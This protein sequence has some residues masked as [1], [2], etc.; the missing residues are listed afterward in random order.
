MGSHVIPFLNMG[1]VML[2]FHF[3]EVRPVS[4][5]TRNRYA[6]WIINSWPPYVII[7]L[8]MLSMPGDLRFFSLPIAAYT[9]CSVILFIIIGIILRVSSSS[10]SVGRAFRSAISRFPVWWSLHLFLRWLVFFCF[11]AYSISSSDPRTGHVPCLSNIS[12]SS[13]SWFVLLHC[14]FCFLFI[15]PI[16]L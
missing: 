7:S 6:I 3:F 1:T 13:S 2:V 9:S 4:L 15:S 11:V 10:S 14:L 16:F 8:I 12:P 5:M